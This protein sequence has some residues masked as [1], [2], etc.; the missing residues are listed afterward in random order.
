MSV[1]SFN[2]KQ[3][4]NTTQEKLNETQIVQQQQQQQQMSTNTTSHTDTS[5][6]TS[7]SNRIDFQMNNSTVVES[8]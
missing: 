4:A 1:C 5:T 2:L 6:S 8:S 3:T 7:S